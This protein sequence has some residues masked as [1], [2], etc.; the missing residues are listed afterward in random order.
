MCIEYVTTYCKSLIPPSKTLQRKGSTN[1]H[2]HQHMETVSPHPCQYWVLKISLLFAKL[3]ASFSFAEMLTTGSCHKIR[4]YGPPR[5]LLVN[6]SKRKP[7]SNLPRAHLGSLEYSQMVIRVILQRSGGGDLPT[8]PHGFQGGFDLVG[9][10]T[11]SAR[12]QQITDI[13]RA[14]SQLIQPFWATYSD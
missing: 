2:S 1:F 11:P 12:C 10:G 5:R 9:C 14:E 7:P 4:I 8:E 3:M 13:H 6:A